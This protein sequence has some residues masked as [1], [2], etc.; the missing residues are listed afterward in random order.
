MIKRESQASRRLFL[1]Q[2]CK[3][4]VKI[5]VEHFLTFLWRLYIV[6]LLLDGA[7]ALRILPLFSIF[8][9]QV[10]MNGWWLFVYMRY[11]WIMGIFWI[12]L[13]TWDLFDTTH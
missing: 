3:S 1:M 2:A 6:G 8:K 9:A 11:V 4:F 12:Y 13:L 5:H 10:M 7:M